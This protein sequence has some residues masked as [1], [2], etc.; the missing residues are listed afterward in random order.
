MSSI[1]QF[2]VVILLATLTLTS[3]LSALRGYQS[4][5]RE[6]QQLFDAQLKSLALLLSEL[7]IQDRQALLKSTRSS[8]PDVHNIHFQIWR[9]QH[10]LQASTN[11]PER[12]FRDLHS[13]YDDNNF[14]GYRWRTFAYSPTADKW[15]LVAQ[16][17]DERYQLAEGIIL[18]AI[19]PI[20]ISI[21]FLGLLIWL[22]VGRGLSP[23]NK[24]AHELEQKRSD[25]LSPLSSN[26]TTPRELLPVISSSNQLFARL[27]A[28]FE[29]EKRFS[30]D[31]AHELR[32]PISVLKVHLHNLE[33]DLPANNDSLE[34][35]SS[36]VNRMQHLVEQMLTLYRTTPEAFQQRKTL[37]DLHDTCQQC[38]I[39]DYQQFEDK[40]QNI[41]LIAD[42]QQNYL[43]EGDDFALKTLLKNL[44]SNAS[45]YTPNEG[46]I[47]AILQQQ[48]NGE[49][50]LIIEDSGPGIPDNEY[51]RI[52]E[53]FYRLAGDRHASGTSGCGLGL[54]IVQHV[55]D[56]HHA[57]ITL[58]HS[59]F[60]SGLA[61]K[62]QFPPPAPPYTQSKEA[63][64]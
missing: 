31:A 55:V 35:L 10:L 19:I 1:R 3:F 22:I 8:S 5:M 56:L 45:K 7:P 17:S 53:R 62:I 29:R 61:V 18:N 58:Q 63:T 14:N 26:H 54:S 57:Q 23:L 21:P 36:G 33:K 40:Q 2:L 25:D 32:T 50:T 12:P 4:S 6:A 49:V 39:E 60:V 46:Q 52:F 15:V 42:A 13:G 64:L 30:A 41:E 38:L 20:V 27:Q 43:I 44:L 34:H 59:S 11:S 9:E 24:L 28:A 37:L 48:E 16:R 47:R 51:S